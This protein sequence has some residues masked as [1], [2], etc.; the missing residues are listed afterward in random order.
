MRVF[1]LFEPALRMIE[2][3]R[4][5]TFAARLLPGW[6]AASARRLTPGLY[7]AAPS[8]DTRDGIFVVRLGGFEPPSA[9]GDDPPA[10]VDSQR[11]RQARSLG[12]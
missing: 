7:A 4:F 1:Q 2:P 11:S 10:A 5:Q 9:G 12:S 8:A 3:G 6:T